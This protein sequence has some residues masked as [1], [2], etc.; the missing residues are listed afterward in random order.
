MTTT[1]EQAKANVLPVPKPEPQPKGRKREHAIYIYGHRHPEKPVC[2][3]ATFAE[4]PCAGLLEHAHLIDQQTLRKL[5]LARYLGDAAVW[6]WACRRHHFG[7]DSRLRV[8]VPRSALSQ[9]TERFA[10][11]HGLGEHLAR[12]FGERAA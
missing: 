6:E 7:F 12:R 11:A 1:S 2:W 4:T 5:G 9:E 3:F 8:F 10:A